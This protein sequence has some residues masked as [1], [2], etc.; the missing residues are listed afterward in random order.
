MQIE[1]V[2]IFNDEHQ[3]HIFH[4]VQLP[5]RKVTSWSA[6]RVNGFLFHTQKRCEGKKTFNCGIYIKGSGEGGYEDDYYGILQDVI[7]NEYLGEPLKQCMMFRCDWF[8]NTPQGTRCRKLYPFVE[9]NVTRRHRKYDPFI[10]AGST[11][12]VVCMKQPNGIRDKSNW[13]V[14]VPNKPR[15]KVNNEFTLP[16]AFQEEHVSHVTPVN[17]TIH[18][19]LLSHEEDIEVVNEEGANKGGAEAEWN[20][21]Y[22]YIEDEVVVDHEDSDEDNEIKGDDQSLLN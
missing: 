18:A 5:L 4:L 10:F 20:D 13:W 19:T 1:I 11:T 12:Q 17:D 3:V 22:K 2:Q 6:F 8:N 16:V 21:D 15:H 7:R 9:A 14:V